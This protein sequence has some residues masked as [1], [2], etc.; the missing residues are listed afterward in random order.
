MALGSHLEV[1][2]ALLETLLGQH[3]L[4][5]SSAT[6]TRGTVLLKMKKTLDWKLLKS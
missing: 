5:V 6:A 4:L 1:S 3:L 2:T